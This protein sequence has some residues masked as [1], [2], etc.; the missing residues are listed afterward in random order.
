MLV[1]RTL[2]FGFSSYCCRLESGG[3]CSALEY[4]VSETLLYRVTSPWRYDITGETLGFYV[5]SAV[6]LKARE[7][8][9]SQARDIDLLMFVLLKPAVDHNMTTRKQQPR[10]YLAIGGEFRRRAPCCRAIPTRGGNK[11]CCS[12]K[13]STKQRLTLMELCLSLFPCLPS[14][15]GGVRCL[16]TWMPQSYR[17]RNL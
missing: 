2:V 11:P 4:F 7:A 13:D 8:D 17:R 14:R 9:L 6:I 12:R 16:V 3:E 10:G 5:F 1:S 15:S